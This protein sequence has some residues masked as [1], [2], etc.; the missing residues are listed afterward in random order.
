MTILVTGGAGFIGSNFILNWF[1]FSD[2]PVVNI[3]LLTYAGNL[4]NLDSIANI[5]PYS[6][7]HGDIN[8]AAL[9][10]DA[11]I[12]HKPR[13]IIH[14]AAET[15]VDQSINNPR[16]FIEANINGTQTLLESSLKYWHSTHNASNADFI[17]LHISTDEVYGSLDRSDLAFTEESPYQPNNPYSASKAASDHLVRAFHRTYGLP[18]IITHCS[19]NYGPYQSPE[20]LIPLMIQRAMSLE[21]LLLYGDGQQIRDWIHVNDHCHALRVI[22]CEGKPGETYNIGGNGEATNISIIESLCA[23]LDQLRPVPA[24]AHINHYD[25]LISLTDDRPGHDQ[26]YAI[27]SQKLST[28]LNWQPDIAIAEGLRTT[29]LWYLANPNWLKTSQDNL[30]KIKLTR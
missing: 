28:E 12:K 24:N 22:L 18:T 7:I 6:F 29:I 20:K 1:N 13:A 27:N 8:N 23:L 5:K 15:H 19:N 30:S 16:K 17:F 3:D 25:E 11:L 2:E 14:F 21:P 10:N 9:V 4:H 26:R